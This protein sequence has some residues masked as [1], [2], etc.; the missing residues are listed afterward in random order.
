MCLCYRLGLGLTLQRTEGSVPERLLLII[1]Q[2]LLHFNSNLTALVRR[3]FF[4]R[5][6]KN[7][8]NSVWP[9]SGHLE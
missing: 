3:K 5:F 2:F 7:L 4:Q 9:P 1:G 8:M 6:R